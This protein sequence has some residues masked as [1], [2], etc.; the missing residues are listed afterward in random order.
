M[1]HKRELELISKANQYYKT[2]D[3]VG[4][5]A[6]LEEV[7]QGN[8]K[9]TDASF[10]LANV[11]HAR[12]YIGKAIKYFSK[13][14]ELDPNHTDAAISLSILFNDIGQYDQAK[15]VFEKANEKVK[16]KSLA[17]GV[18]DPHINKKFSTKHF[19]LGDL[20][21]TYNRFDEALFEYNKAIGLDPANL[22]LRVKLAKVYAKKGFNSRAFDEL[23]KIKNEYPAYIPARIALGILHYGSGNVV[24]AQNEWMSVLS[25]DPSNSEAQMYINLSKTASETTLS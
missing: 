25:R 12:G 14:T 22:D 15:S 9:N 1:E 23:K 13:T 4:A 7:L 2:K 3:Y 5:Q 16:S 6:V 8:P 17:A 24:D 20:Y 10:M 21:L 11:F 18:E 19:E